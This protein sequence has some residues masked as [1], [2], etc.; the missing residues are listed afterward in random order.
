MP[1][2]PMLLPALQH[3]HKQQMSHEAANNGTSSLQVDWSAP[4]AR[5]RFEKSQSVTAAF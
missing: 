4:D 5:K 2:M 3:R 1:P